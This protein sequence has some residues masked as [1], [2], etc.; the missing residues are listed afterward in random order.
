MNRLLESLDALTHA[1]DLRCFPIEADDAVFLE[2]VE[3]A[4]QAGAFE[5]TAVRMQSDRDTAD[6]LDHLGLVHWLDHADR[7]VG[8]PP[9]KIIDGIG[10]HVFVLVLGMA[11]AQDPQNDR[12]Y[13]LSHG[14]ACPSSSSC[15]FCN[16]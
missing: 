6:A 9:L 13:F 7:N 16:H 3:R 10:E 11:F 12:S 2:G 8:L 1:A 15:S 5:I 14:L 4:R